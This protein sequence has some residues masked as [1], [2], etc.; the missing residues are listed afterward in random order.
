MYGTTNDRKGRTMRVR[1]IGPIKAKEKVKKKVC[2]Y[3]RVSTFTSSQGES[4]ENQ[5]SYYE[6]VLSANPEYEFVGVFADRG[7]TGTKANRKE[8]IKMLV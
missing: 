7:L 1:I 5:V 8:F 3:V 2:A 4:F 6:R